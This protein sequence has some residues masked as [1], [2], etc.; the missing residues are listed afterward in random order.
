MEGGVGARFGRSQVRRIKGDR[1]QRAHG[2]VGEFE[3]LERLCRS[4][5]AAGGKEQ[6]GGE[7]GENPK[8][9]ARALWPEDK[10]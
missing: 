2:R 9:E 4:R 5:G 8:A 7:E 3:A 10:P 6:K 1:D